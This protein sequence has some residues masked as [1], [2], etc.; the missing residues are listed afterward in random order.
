M[1]TAVALAS[2]GSRSTLLV[3][4][5]GDVELLFGR[6][7]ARTGLGQWLAAENP[8]PD[9]LSRLEID[10][11]PNLSLL[12]WGQE[13]GDGRFGEAAGHTEGG[14]NESAPPVTEAVA[15][16]VTRPSAEPGTEDRVALLA[17]LVEVDDR[18][19][20]VDLGTRSSAP[21]PSATLAGELLLFASRSTLVTRACYL[22]I[23]A[24]QPW[25]RPDEVVVV[26]RQ[27]RALRSADVSAAVG[28]PV[29]SE[30]RW[31]PA[32]ARVVDAGLF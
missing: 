17:R 13:S 2:A 31:D 11:A 19:V 9:A 25:P 22:A 5:A 15:G 1:A 28:A 14:G 23:R 4:L 27:G 18:T 26:A 20:I 7:P 8:P 6:A 3:D 10:L 30:V 21:T 29:V 32:V 16:P 24:A 12:P